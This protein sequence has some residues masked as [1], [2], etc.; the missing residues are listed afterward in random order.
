MAIGGREPVVAWAVG[1]VSLAVVAGIV[2]AALPFFPV[3][4]EWLVG[5]VQYFFDWLRSITPAR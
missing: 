4:G 1:L 3:V 5:V 2:W